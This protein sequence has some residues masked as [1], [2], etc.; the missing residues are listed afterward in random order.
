MKSVNL[1]IIIQA[2]M[3]STRLPGKVLK[4]INKKPALWYVLKRLSQISQSS[5]YVATSDLEIDDQIVDFVSQFNNV[6]VFR[7]S[8]TDIVQRFNQCLD[9]IPDINNDDI[10]VR[11]CAD[12]YMI[13]PSI[14]MKAVNIILNQDNIDVVNPFINTQLLFGCGAEVSRVGIIREIYNFTRSCEQHLKEH[15]FFYAYKNPSIYN[16]VS[17]PC[18]KTLTHQE[19]NI[20]VDTIKDFEFIR[21]WMESIGVEACISYDYDDIIQSIVEF[22]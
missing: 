6:K 21:T 15:L 12:N 18:D 17:L 9:S 2:R 10:V 20:S 22:C 11:V 13:C 3:S 5:I 7:G 14:V 16:C 19:I 1:H 4:E 8:H